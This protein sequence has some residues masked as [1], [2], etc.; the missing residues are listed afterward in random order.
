MAAAL[1]RRA[2]LVEVVCPVRDYVDL[3]YELADPGTALGRAV[4]T[5]RELARADGV[6]R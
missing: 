1:A 6:M 2:A 5:Q 4:L 3:S